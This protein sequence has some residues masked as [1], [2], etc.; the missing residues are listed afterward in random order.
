[1]TAKEILE[2]YK[3]SNNYGRFLDMDFEIIKPGSVRYKL[4]IREEHLATPIAAHGGVV[5]GLIDGAIGVAGLTHAAQNSQLISTVSL[6]I[7]YLKPVELGDELT[8]FGTVISAGKRLIYTEASVR[9]QNDV[10]VAKA[11]GV[12]NAFPA[13]KAFG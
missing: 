13:E 12:L 5:A 9:N 8:A 11:S 4:K 6:N 7:N 10:E 1:M 3:E 2:R